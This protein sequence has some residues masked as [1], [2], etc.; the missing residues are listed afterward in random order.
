MVIHYRWAFG[1]LSLLTSFGAMAGAISGGNDSKGSFLNCDQ[2]V[3]RIDCTQEVRNYIRNKCYVVVHKSPSPNAT[4]NTFQYLS[5]VGS[6]PKYHPS[7]ERLEEYGSFFAAKK[8]SDW[9]CDPQNNCL[10]KFPFARHY[11]KVADALQKRAENQNSD[12]HQ[13]LKGFPNILLEGNPYLACAMMGERVLLR[14]GGSSDVK[15]ARGGMMVESS[16]AEAACNKYRDSLIPADLAR[17]GYCFV[18]GSDNG[19]GAVQI[20]KFAPNE[21]GGKL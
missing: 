15:K 12:L 14:Y 4:W 10:P 3:R 8:A 20:K 11:L 9:E 16:K 21:P 13:K 1:L 6:L 5:V 2:R 7:T 18:G 17:E 19:D